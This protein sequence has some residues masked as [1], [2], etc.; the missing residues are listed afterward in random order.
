MRVERLTKGPS[1]A[2]LNKSK[3]VLSSLA[4]QSS[5]LLAQ[6]CRS[7]RVSGTPWLL[8]RKSL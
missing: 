1:L 7:A 3:F 5:T 2:S 8:T 6:V 4:I